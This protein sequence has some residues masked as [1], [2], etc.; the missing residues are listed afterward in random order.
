MLLEAFGV[1][2]LPS[3]WQEFP[4]RTVARE[5]KGNKNKGLIEN[6]LLSLS[7]GNIVRKDIEGSGGLLPESFD[8]YQI[9][10]SGDLVMRLTDL[11]ND[12]RSLR[13]G[14]A[15]E[16]GII[17]SAYLTLTP[18]GVEPRYFAYLFRAYDVAKILYPLGG[19]LRQSIGY[20][21]IR[22][23]PIVVPPL[24]EQRRIAD[25]LDDQ[26]NL[27]NQAIA[28]KQGQ[29]VLLH[30]AFDASLREKVLGNGSQDL[31]WASNIGDDRH[32]Q[33]IGTLLKIRGEKNDPISVTQI[34]SLTASRGV[35]KYEDKGDIG[36]KAS[37]DI[38]RYNI[39]RKGDIV[40]NC[41]NVILGSVGQSE[42]EGVL[43]PV[44]YVMCPVNQDQV[45]MEFLAL[46]FRVREFQKQLIKLGNGILEHRMRIPWINLKA[47]K[48]AIP[49][50]E[51]QARIVTELHEL[52]RN[53]QQSLE[54]LNAGIRL[55][56][57]RKRSLITAAVTGQ[58]DVSA[59]RS[60][61]GL[62]VSGGV[63]ASVDSP[64][65]ADGLAL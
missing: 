35:I 44:Y 1:A 45:N 30:E 9:V 53:R 25:F 26:V 43:S 14:L 28:L 37:E 52:D 24:D 15:T 60:L 39:V 31:G 7:F 5:R 21:D 54:I 56:E 3:G 49:S 18:M 38:S 47:E 59:S 4:L 2:S 13:S 19:G 22:Q 17:T 63:S 29:F 40:L 55:L 27:I 62:R 23:L 65:Y 32:L 64:S 10:E 46:H 42:Y 34:L 51:I 16:R 36:N 6:N 20:E 12:K 58:L 33:P 61:T 57:E 41:M 8:G 50:L 11:Q 48:L